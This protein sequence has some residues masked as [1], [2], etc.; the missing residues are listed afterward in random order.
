M[1]PSLIILIIIFLIV[2]LRVHRRRKL[3]RD[4]FEG[5]AIVGGVTMGQ[6]ATANFEKNMFNGAVRGFLYGITTG[7]LVGGATG[8][9]TS[10][11]VTPIIME[12]C[13]E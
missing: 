7:G 5:K 4:G 2:S 8:A 6:N 1:S 11:M 12:L 10:C 3:S 13:G 9:A